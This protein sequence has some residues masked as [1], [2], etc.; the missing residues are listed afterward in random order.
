MF[1]G[2]GWWI[3]FSLSL[4]YYLRICLVYWW[5]TVRFETP[6]LCNHLILFYIVAS[7]FVTIFLS[8]K[9]WEQVIIYIW[10]FVLNL[11]KDVI[12]FFYSSMYTHLHSHSQTSLLTQSFVIFSFTHLPK[13]DLL[14]I[15]AKYLKIWQ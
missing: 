6:A 3:W 2:A 8:F 10:C 1:S 9:F 12:K 11:S 14:N 5:N 4:F 13:K 7:L 15:C